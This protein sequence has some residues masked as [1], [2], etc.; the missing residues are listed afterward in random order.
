MLWLTFRANITAKPFAFT[1]S[2]DGKRI[3]AV[4][5]CVFRTEQ[6]FMVNNRTG[7]HVLEDYFFRKHHGEIQ[8]FC[9]NKI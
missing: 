6:I 3:S 7:F 5:P 4:D 2:P 8:E 9:E 1:C